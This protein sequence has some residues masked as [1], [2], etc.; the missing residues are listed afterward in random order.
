MRE[1]HLPQ[2]E[3]RYEGEDEGDESDAMDVAED[4]GVTS[5]TSSSTIKIPKKSKPSAPPIISSSDETKATET[6]TTQTMDTELTSTAQ[7]GGTSSN[8]EVRIRKKQRL[9]TDPAVD[10]TA[11]K[12]F[13]LDSIFSVEGLLAYEDWSPKI[14]KNASL[15]HL[16]PNFSLD[17]NQT[18]ALKL[19]VIPTN[20]RWSVN[21]CPEDPLEMVD[22]YMHFNPRYKTNE[23][24]LNDVQGTWGGYV[25]Q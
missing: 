15:L 18:V 4:V 13:G 20:G 12:T 24:V 8:A 25:H 11:P 9:L 10:T 7:S 2:H 19:S 6:S 22:V 3:D 16:L 14:S 1:E 17:G 21:I 23:V 5:S